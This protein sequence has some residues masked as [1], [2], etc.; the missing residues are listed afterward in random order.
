MKQ[1]NIMLIAIVI[2]VVLVLFFYTGK[3]QEEHTS[4][5]VAFISLSHVD[6]NTFDGFKTQMEKY[7]WDENKNIKYIVPGAAHKVENLESIVKS[8]I[9]KNPDLILV[10]STPATQEVKKQVPCSDIPIVFSPVNDPVASNIVQNLKMPE[11][12]ITGIRLPIGDTKRFEW[13][14]AIA[15]SV[16]TVLVPYT[17]ND[18][19]SIASRDNIKEIAKE[20][21]IRII[22]KALAEGMAIEDFFKTVP[23]SIE[24]IFLPRDSRIEV[25]IEEFVKFSLAKK[26]PLSAPSYQQVEKGA[27]FTF[28]FIHKELGIEA[29]R[30]VDR[31][32]K[33]VKPAD[34]PVKFGN[35]YLVINQKTAKIIG[36][37]FPKNALRNAKLIIE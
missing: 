30:M 31:I 15:P 27:L 13:L 5:T 19:S 35:A 26:L 17:P 32:L 22:E 7:G 1:K 9:Q 25:R 12:C 10:S 36:I 6:D 21:N 28:G 29:A 4:K 3:P 18:D 11:A 20:L 16:K 23:D 14:Y 34:L 24:A 8:V 2:L 33:G 37:E